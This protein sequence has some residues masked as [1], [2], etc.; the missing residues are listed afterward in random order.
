MIIRRVN[1]KSVVS[2]CP[3]MILIMLR[4]FL[5]PFILGGSGR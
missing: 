4:L 5:Y 2:Y 1:K 3:L